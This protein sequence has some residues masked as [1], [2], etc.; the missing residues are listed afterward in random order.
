MDSSSKKRLVSNFT[1]TRMVVTLF[2]CLSLLGG[3]SY[4]VEAVVRRLNDGE[5]AA[6][7]VINNK[8]ST[9]REG[10]CVNDQD[11]ATHC[12]SETY[13]GGLCLPNDID[14]E[15]LGICCCLY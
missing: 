11:C 10:Y 3:F 9:V 8:C 15:P 5:V 7:E 4:S 1:T 12:R 2:L 13:S 14:E 6:R